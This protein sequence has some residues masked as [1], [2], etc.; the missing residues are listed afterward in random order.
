MSDRL[1]AAKRAIAE[2]RW[3]DA[4]S[5]LEDAVTQEP[6]N[7][8]VLHTLVNIYIGAEEWER[9]AQ[10]VRRMIVEAS[11]ASP[12]ERLEAYCWLAN[13]SLRHDGAL[14][15]A[16]Y[17]AIG[18]YLDTL[19]SGETSKTLR[20]VFHYASNL[21]VGADD[22]ARGDQWLR[23][24]FPEVMGAGMR[25]VISPVKGVK[26]WCREAEA[27]YRELEPP[28]AI[29]ARNGAHTWSY[30]TEPYSVAAIPQGELLCGWD[31]PMAPS[32]EVLAAPEKLALSATGWFTHAYSG[33]SARVL[34][35][36]SDEVKYVHED[37]LM[38]SG[39]QR[40]HP[41]HW[42]A[43]YLPRLRVV[44]EGGLQG[45]KVAI[46]KELPAKQRES[47][48]LFGID[49]NQVLECDAGRRYRFR[50]VVAVR[51]GEPFHFN[52]PTTHFLA[53]GFR[54]SPS[55]GPQGK[56]NIFLVRSHPTRRILNMDEVRSL[57]DSYG[58]DFLDLATRTMPQQRIDLADAE[59]VVCTYGSDLLAVLS[60]PPGSDLI[61]LKYFVEE[62]IVTSCTD[63]MFSMLSVNYHH[64]VC[65]KSLDSGAKRKKK[66]F[67]FVVNCHELEAVL[68]GIQDRK[69][70]GQECHSPIDVTVE[71][72]G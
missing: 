11:V 12:A 62:P 22:A 32:G 31:F 71:P 10:H 43:E 13:V 48:A 38:L 47:L 7:R 26:E 46:P 63:P 66:D 6:A 56:K 20:K 1:F 68:K 35:P 65:D 39:G 16:E 67:D 2:S 30:K 8:E 28:Q 40:F 9:A 52:V 42:I 14:F 27:M 57:L 4:V 3:S 21:I 36:W 50:H 19:I 54:A 15:G 60:M 24:V 53:R 72:V 17:A 33:Q 34:H 44:K 41:G 18:R 49:G 64:V 37:V 25:A 59:V 45:L 58:F 29:T 70:S 69:A 51:P 23:K 55:T 61:E 5:L